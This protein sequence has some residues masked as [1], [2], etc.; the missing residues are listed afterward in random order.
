MLRYDCLVFVLRLRSA[1]RQLAVAAAN[2]SD[3]AIEELR[4]FALDLC[5]ANEPISVAMTGANAT[6]VP[7]NLEWSTSM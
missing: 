1:L 6:S 3:A 7:T 4:A 5:N 2:A